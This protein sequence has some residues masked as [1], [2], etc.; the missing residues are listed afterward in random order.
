M[1]SVCARTCVCV[2]VHLHTPL[3][4]QGGCTES[5]TGKVAASPVSM[6]CLLL[7]RALASPPRQL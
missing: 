4:S 3:V 2:C 1:I 6:W 5:S 7:A